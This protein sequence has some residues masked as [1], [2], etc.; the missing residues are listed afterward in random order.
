MGICQHAA[1]YMQGGS[2]RGLT[3][4]EVLNDEAT[5]ARVC[6]RGHVNGK[7]FAIERSIKRYSCCQSLTIPLLL[8]CSRLTINKFRA[9][10]AKC[11]LA[12]LDLC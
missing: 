9:N 2:G 7:P 10:K 5:S 11:V 3:S 4:S 8:K 12:E 6:L 1:G